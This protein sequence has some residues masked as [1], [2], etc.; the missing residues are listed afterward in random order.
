M[1]SREH[2]EQTVSA[3]ICLRE[4][5]EEDSNA[6]AKTSQGSVKGTELPVTV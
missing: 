4:E 6:A 1:V 5:A 3:H 2:T